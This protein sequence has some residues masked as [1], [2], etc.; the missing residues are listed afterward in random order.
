LSKSERAKG[1][2]GER[3]VAAI[4][5]HYG[6]DCDRVPNSGG[7]RLKGDLYGTIPAHVEVKRQEVARPW[8]WW[9]QASSEAPEGVAPVVAFRR[10]GSSWLAIVALD[11]LAEL[12]QKAGQ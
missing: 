1:A 7:L 4:F 3:E 8:L 6:F 9:L 12:M 11:H 2:G 5:R 10:N